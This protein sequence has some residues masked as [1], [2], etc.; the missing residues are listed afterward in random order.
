VKSKVLNNAAW[1][2]G[3]R[4]AQSL[5]NL[6]VGM[7][8]A[9]YLGPSNYGLISYAASI[10]AFVTPLMRLGLNATLV[11][12]IT[13]RPDK[14]GTILGTALGLNI[15]SGILCL[16]SVIGFVFFA[17][18]GE[19]ITL[20]VCAVYGLSLLFQATEM[21]TYWFQAKLLSKIPSVA[22]VVAYVFVSCYKIYLL[23]SSK[24][25]YWFAASNAIDHLVISIIL[26]VSYFCISKRRLRF[27][28]D[29]AKQLLSK[30]KFYIIS[31]MMITVFQQTDRLM[32]KN[33]TN[34]E[35]TGYYSAAVTC[36]GIFG[37]VYAA[38]I[39]SARPEILKYKVASQQKYENSIS[40]LYSVIFYLSLLQCV[41]TA[42]FAK[43]III[44]LYGEAYEQSIA[45]LR[46]VVWF[47]TYSYFGSVRNIWILGEEKHKSVM[48]I[49][50][51]GALL[52]VVLNSVLIPVLGLIGACIAS[53][54][55]QFTMN[56]VIGFIFKSLRRNSILMLKGLN[57][58]LLFEM[59]KI[60]LK[61]SA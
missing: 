13:N 50:I 47:V 3:C 33:M 4:I 54:V 12:E 25:V 18:R 10:V 42:L 15:P 59:K 14:E 24:S 48:F 21:I 17:N 19:H 8:S 39:D 16:L 9:R 60:L 23:S 2:I 38:I 31:G 45:A 11:Q 7:L 34:D 26:I 51:S 36:A 43:P 37:F 28:I 61:K 30:S 1:I 58:K 20:V 57:P 29:M 46:I 27:S 49:D 40:C 6:I 44:I 55:T 52:N 5:L 56:F 35:V 41:I 22:M 32:L 53:V